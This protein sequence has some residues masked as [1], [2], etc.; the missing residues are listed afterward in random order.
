MSQVL[1]QNPDRIWSSDSGLSRESGKLRKVIEWTQRHRN[2]PVSLGWKKELYDLAME[3]GEEYSESG[4]DGYN[5]DP[6]TSDAVIRTLRL[7]YQLSEMIQ[8]PNLIPSSGGYISFEW[9]DSERRVVS[10]SPKAELMVW[11]AVLADDDTQYGKSPIRKGWPSGVLNI[12]HEFFSR[13]RPVH[14]R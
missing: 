2:E 9:H 12:L 5:A 3:I 8:P 14:T 6:I 7:I 10:V 4:W 11:A 13:S 1:R